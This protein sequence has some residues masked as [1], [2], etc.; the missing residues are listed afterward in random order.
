MQMAAALENPDGGVDAHFEF[1][2]YMIDE[3]GLDGNFY[4]FRDGGTCNRANDLAEQTGTSVNSGIPH[5]DGGRYDYPTYR[6]ATVAFFKRLNS[7]LKQRWSNSKIV[8]HPWTIYA[9]YLG[10]MAHLPDRHE[11]APDMVFNEKD[12]TEFADIFQDLAKASVLEELGIQKDSVGTTHPNR[13]AAIGEAENRLVAAR[14]AVNG[15]WYN[16]FNRYDE[17]GNPNFSRLTDIY[18]RLK[19]IR[20]VPGWD[21]LSR[22]PVNPTHR[23]WNNNRTN[24]IYDS[25]D[26]TLEPQSHFSGQLIYSRHWQKKSQVFAVFLGSGEPIRLKRGEAIVRVRRVN[27]YFEED[28]TYGDARGELVE[29][30]V[31]GR[32]ELRLAGTVGI[33]NGGLGCIIT[34]AP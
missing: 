3:P 26:A 15:S 32:V 31:A 5:H 10:P 7:R 21:N 12:G 11:L 24:P 16:W 8:Y 1:G 28:S 17:D 6:E 33:P 2:G 4:A 9:G 19:L 20:V 25:V 27:G 22:I 30:S 34:V 13:D 14:A 18:P 23:V 29:S